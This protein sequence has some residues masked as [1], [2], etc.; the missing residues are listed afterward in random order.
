MAGKFRALFAGLEVN[1]TGTFTYK[2]PKSKGEV[3]N[4]P[5]QIVSFDAENITFNFYDLKKLKGIFNE[6]ST[7]N[8]NTRGRI[9]N[10]IPHRSSGDPEEIANH[11]SSGDPEEIANNNL[12]PN[13]PN[14]LKSR[15]NRKTRKTRK[16]RKQ[17]KL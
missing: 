10:F 11:R 15:K 16:N 13:S 14:T 2:S 9:W 17:K 6:T 4:T 5:A 1:K 7:F 3:Y 12:K 8:I